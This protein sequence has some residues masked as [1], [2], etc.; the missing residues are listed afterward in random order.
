MSRVGDGSHVTDDLFY[1]IERTATLPS[2]LLLKP[3][4]FTGTIGIK[5]W[6]IRT[7]PRTETFAPWRWR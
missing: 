4:E 5:F 6:P 2:G 3:T 7:C 1:A